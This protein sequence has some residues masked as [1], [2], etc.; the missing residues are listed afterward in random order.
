MTKYRILF[1]KQIFMEALV[2][3]NDEQE[4]LLKVDN[5]ECEFNEDKFSLPDSD[6]EVVSIKNE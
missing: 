3:A 5:S 2:E 6:W 4:A 1:S